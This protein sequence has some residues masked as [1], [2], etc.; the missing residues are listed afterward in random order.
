VYI[1]HMK[2]GE[3]NWGRVRAFIRGIRAGLK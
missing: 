2:E 1:E 3:L